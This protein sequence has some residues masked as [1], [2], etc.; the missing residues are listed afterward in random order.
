MAAKT[1]HGAR[2]LIQL[3][4]PGQTTAKN[5]GIWMSCSYSVAY[6]VN[7]VYILGRFSAAELVTTAIEPV[8]ITCQGWRVVDHGPM[9]EAGFTNVSDLLNQG[10]IVLKVYDRQSK[11]YVANIK[12]CKPTGTS[13]G[14]SAKN[15]MD[16]S[17]TYLGL[18]MDDESTVQ[19]ETGND[20]ATLP[21]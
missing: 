10:D 6:D 4:S 8:N 1:M 13:S 21:G 9:V 19:E 16:M 20:V 7:P 12:G 17:N 15:L 5:V 2:A 18:L 3:I 11:K 14:A